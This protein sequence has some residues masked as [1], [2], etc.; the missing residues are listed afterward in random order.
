MCVQESPSS[1]R[2]SVRSDAQSGA[3]TPLREGVESTAA[4]NN[5]VDTDSSSAN[6]QGGAGIQQTARNPPPRAGPWKG[7]AAIFRRRPGPSPLAP[8]EA[9]ADL[10]R[11]L[12]QLQEPQ[13]A[14][15]SREAQQRVRR[16]VK[17]RAPP[18]PADASTQPSICSTPPS[19]FA[20]DPTGPSSFSTPRSTVVNSSA[21]WPGDMETEARCVVC[22]APVPHKSLLPNLTTRDGSVATVVA[23]QRRSSSATSES[24][25]LREWSG[26]G[27]LPQCSECTRRAAAARQQRTYAPPPFQLL[28]CVACSGHVF[29]VIPVHAYFSESTTVEMSVQQQQTEAVESQLQICPSK[30][31][32]CMV[33]VSTA[34]DEFI[35]SHQTTSVGHN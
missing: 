9:A 23:G 5:L 7:L 33:T 27:M 31:V 21:Q 14:H 8:P 32:Y 34:S 29:E 20:D 12:E 1:V 35:P 17:T 15:D 22:N 19:P 10:R 30:Q 4:A 24:P 11:Q 25:S 6:R 26:A 13:A 2:G 3:Q 16:R 28:A 18:D